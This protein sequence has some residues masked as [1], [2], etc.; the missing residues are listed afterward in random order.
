MATRP[1][2]VFVMQ[3]FDWDARWHEVQAALERHEAR[4]F[5]VEWHAKKADEREVER[6]LER[7]RVNQEHIAWLERERQAKAAPA[8]VARPKPKPKS[9]FDRLLRR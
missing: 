4:K 8:I 2:S 9:F 5:W 7:E 1:C 3:L 6:R